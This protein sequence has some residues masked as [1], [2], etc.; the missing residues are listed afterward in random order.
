MDDANYETDNFVLGSSFEQFELKEAKKNSERLEQVQDCL[1]TENH[2]AVGQGFVCISDCHSEVDATEVSKWRSNFPYVRVKGN[3]IDS[4]SISS[5]KQ[6]LSKEAAFSSQVTCGQTASEDGD[7]GQQPVHDALTQF[8]TSEELLVTDGDI[9]I[10]AMIHFTGGV[11][12]RP[13]ISEDLV[14]EIVSARVKNAWSLLTEELRPF[15]QAVIT[16]YDA[17]L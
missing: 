7:L 6:V 1:Y 17:D 14:S 2:N 16:K 9:P 3:A 12:N 10:D 11:T 13:L 15:I 8:S 4:L 5:T